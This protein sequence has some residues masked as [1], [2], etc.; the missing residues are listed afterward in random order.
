MEYEFLE[1]LRKGL[2]VFFV[3]ALPV[4]ELRGAIPYGIS[5]LHLGQ[6]PTLI[7]AIL[8]NFF[9]CYFI[10]KLFDPFTKFLFQHLPWL[11]NHIQKYFQKI[12][13][14]HSEK[15]NRLGY[16]ALATFVA[17]P[18]PGTGAW[19]GALIAYLL[20]FPLI[21]TLISLFVG[22]L[23]AAAIVTVSWDTIAFFYTMIMAP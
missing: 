2:Q 7:F 12:H 9:P 10:L 3:A 20:A 8:G 13:H 5:V 6:I 1:L 23:G 18:L 22:I 19:T 17:I 15:F 4:L 21:P 14:K 16:I 11:H